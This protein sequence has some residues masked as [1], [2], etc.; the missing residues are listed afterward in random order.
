MFSPQKWPDFDAAHVYFRL[1]RLWVLLDSGST[2]VTRKAAAEQ[3]G[4][5]QK[6]HPHELQ[7]LLKK[8]TKY[9]EPL[10]LFCLWLHAGIPRG[11]CEGYSITHFRF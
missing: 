1:D 4:E 2:P 7:N 5:V 11:I 10:L 9:K 6:L 8:V 3:I